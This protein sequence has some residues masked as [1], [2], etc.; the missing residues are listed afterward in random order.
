MSD[1]GI[2]FDLNDDEI[3]AGGY[4]PFMAPELFDKTATLNSPCDVYSYG[5]C[6]LHIFTQVS[7]QFTGKTV[8]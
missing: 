7:P 1:Y 3:W 8:S 5:I 4:A 2:P 6:L